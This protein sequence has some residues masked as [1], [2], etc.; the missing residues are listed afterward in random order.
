MNDLQ[1]MLIGQAVTQNALDTKAINDSLSSAGVRLDCCGDVY[2]GLARL[3]I[4]E[5]GKYLAA[6][7]CVDS[8]GPLEM[9]FFSVASRLCRDLPIYAYGN[10]HSDSKIKQ[11]VGLGAA[12]P[13]NDQSIHSLV[14]NA[15]E[16][17]RK[18][19][20]SSDESCAAPAK[21]DAESETWTEPGQRASQSSSQGHDGEEATVRVPWQ[22]YGVGPVRTPPGQQDAPL[23]E[24][25][26]ADK[27]VTPKP[28][29][30][31]PLLTPEELQA[32][33]GDDEDL[34]PGG[35]VRP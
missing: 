25:A 11:A 1:V 18:L 24:A 22:R 28:A 19:I 12:G 2:R 27:P 30:Y 33:L 31:E 16:I 15:D 20:R 32:L 21:S 6:V 35:H 17:R 4:A 9:Q 29:S 5:R 3:G 26:A 7:V 10:E 13:F 23:P 34:A 14:K 8:L